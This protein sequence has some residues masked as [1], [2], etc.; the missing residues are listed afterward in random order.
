MGQLNHPNPL[1]LIGYCLEDE[2][3]ILVYEYLDKGS[4]DKCLF[5]SMLLV[6]LLLL[7][8]FFQGFLFVN[9]IF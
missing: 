2:D 6:F 3:P 5:E 1:K 9:F 7:L 4:S 8:S